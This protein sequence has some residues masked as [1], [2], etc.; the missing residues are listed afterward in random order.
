VTMP[1]DAFDSS[2]GRSADEALVD[3][4]MRLGST[5]DDANLVLV[6]GE[7]PRRTALVALGVARAQAQRRRV[8]LGDL[9]GDA[10]PIQQLLNTDD[11]HGL[12]DSFV[13]GVSLNKI[14]RAVPQYGDLY[15]LPSGSEVPEYEEIFTNARWR[16]LIAGF[17][18]TGA[19]LVVAA[20]SNAS[21]VADVVQLGD[22]AILVGAASLAAVEP[23][24]LLGRAGI[25]PPPN[26]QP[27]PA[28]L[29]AAADMA[30]DTSL[31]APVELARPWWKPRIGAPA[32][33]AAIIG[34]IGIT[35]L[36]LWIAAPSFGNRGSDETRSR[37]TV[38]AAAGAVPSTLDSLR[39]DSANMT[40]TAGTLRAANP[41]D[42]LGAASYS[43]VIARYN[44]MR[45]AQMWLQS[46]Q[47]TLPVATF[48]PQIVQGETWYRAIAGA[49]PTRA[50]A[51]SLLGTFVSQGVSRPDSN[52]LIRAPLAFL[53]DSV[54]A[55]AVAGLLKYY[56]DRG[57]PVY[58]LR[59]PDGSARLY[60]GAYDSPE[61][62][63]LDTQ[64]VKIAGIR[65]ILVYR[66]G[67][68]Y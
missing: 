68:V 59:Q 49:Y 29:L 34:A 26:E 66:I 35:A 50:Q 63:A 43:V 4:G 15:V 11:P 14:A 36:A 51:D 65:P 10:E 38:S 9:L 22:G 56:A 31:A 1:M 61:A 54:K 33:I 21:H 12:A 67:R 53:L 7:E 55:Q 2:A 28:A 8:A 57:E 25:A 23:G 24:K 18:E 17:R 40:G 27:E 47:R 3:E 37:S 46:N 20:P 44:T 41:G 58:A 64:A 13:Y 62:A 6:L 5:V 45:G 32:A 60:W 42:S 16:R 19:L 48:G 30:P 52:N 39:A